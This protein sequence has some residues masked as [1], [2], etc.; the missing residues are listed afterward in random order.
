MTQPLRCIIA[1]VVVAVVAAGCQSSGSTTGAA[2][3]EP[4]PTV[5]PDFRVN[6]DLVGAGESVYTN[7]GCFMCHRIGEGRAAGPDLFGVT[8]R[9]TIDWLTNFLKNTSEML[10][11]DPIAHALL[12]E[13]KFQ[14]MPQIA[15]TDRDIEALIHYLQHA[16]NRRR[17]SGAQ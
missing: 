12:E 1:S 16:T 8:E 5:N 3:T 11:S 15:M 14:R 10:D 17:A 6:A 7:R 9:R 4:A 2:S 13:F